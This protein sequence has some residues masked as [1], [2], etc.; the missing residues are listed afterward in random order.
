MSEREIQEWLTH[1]L[2]AKLRM[3]P[4]RFDV[5]RPLEEY[6]L[7]S[8]EAIALMGELEEWLRHPVHPTAL[9]D[10]RTVAQ[11]ASFLDRAAAAARG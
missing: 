4:E 1:K 8:L 9:W 2:A 10:H 11:L 3:P 5:H 7:D 6:G